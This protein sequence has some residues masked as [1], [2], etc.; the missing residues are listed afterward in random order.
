MKIFLSK[1]NKFP[2]IFSNDK[3][4]DIDLKK[5]LC[6]SIDLLTF[7][8]NFESP[9]CIYFSISSLNNSEDFEMK[10]LFGYPR[11]DKSE[12]F[13]RLRIKEE[14][15]RE[16]IPYKHLSEEIGNKSCKA[17][18]IMERRKIKQDQGISRNGDMIMRNK[19]ILSAGNSRLRDNNGSIDKQIKLT[20]ERRI[21][22][23]SSLK[24]KNSFTLVKHDLCKVVKTINES[25]NKENEILEN[26]K[27]S[28][29]QFIRVLNFFDDLYNLHHRKSTARKNFNIMIF[30]GKFLVMR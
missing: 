12:F 28:W 13:Q 20:K 16:A 7:Y 4:F 22:E 6:F 10:F 21:I 25:H 8:Q 14:R 9:K 1:E 24:R 26:I 17:E 27:S 29:V 30:K 11:M 3:K 18:R 2:S 15:T 23:E 5:N 19:R